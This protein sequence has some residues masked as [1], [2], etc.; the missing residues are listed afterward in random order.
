MA[1]ASIGEHL[2]DHGDPRH[3]GAAGW[4]WSALSNQGRARVPLT[5][6]RL[7]RPE[8]NPNIRAFRGPL[9]R[10]RSIDER[11]ILSL[12]RRLE[13][14]VP[15]EVENIPPGMTTIAKCVERSRMT[16]EY[17][18]RRLLSG[19]IRRV[20]RMANVAGFRG[21][22]IDPKEFSTPSNLP[23]PGMSTEMVMLVLGLNQVATNS[24]LR[25]REGGAL[26]DV[27]DL[28]GRHEKWVSPEALDRFRKRFVFG[29]RLQ[30]EYRIK[31]SAAKSLLDAYGVKPLFNPREFGAMIYHRADL[32]PEITKRTT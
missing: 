24:L 21:V 11:E 1:V 4:A 32:P 25:E 20:F 6:S 17:V 28:P 26:L 16:N 8:I 14:L 30:L 9:H 31:R 22:V 5:Q 3:L 10:L 29:H 19:R 27:V 12:L 18:L 7:A 15:R 2:D 23:L 13:S